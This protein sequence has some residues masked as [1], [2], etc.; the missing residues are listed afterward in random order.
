[1]HFNSD[2]EYV[3]ETDLSDHAQKDVLFQYNKNNILRSIVYFLYKLNVTESNYKIY[4]KK[5]L[6]II[7]CFEQWHS[8]LKDSLFSVKILTDHKNL[9][10][11]ITTKQL[12]HQQTQWTE[13]LSWFDFKIMYQSDKQDQKSDILTWQSQDLPMNSS[14]ERIANWLWILLLFK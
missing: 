3:F 4:N 12:T 7:Q 1:M 2:L 10:Y 14:D 5:L 9:Q 13:Y 8:E 6:V 11:F